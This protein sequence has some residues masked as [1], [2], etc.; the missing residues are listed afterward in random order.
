MVRAKFI[1]R[2]VVKTESGHDITLEPVTCGSQENETF[3]RYTPWGQIR[4]G[5]VSDDAAKQFVVGEEFYVD[6]TPA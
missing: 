4:L 6:F 2:A 3:Y 5:T 1:C